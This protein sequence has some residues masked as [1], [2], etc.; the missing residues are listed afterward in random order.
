MG[1][2]RLYRSFPADPP[3]PS[4]FKERDVEW[5][6][7]VQVRIWRK[8]GKPSK[9]FLAI[10]DTGSP[11]CLFQASMGKAIGLDLEA[12]EEHPISGVVAGAELTA[13]FHRICL[14]VEDTW[15]VEV[16]AG[17]LEGFSVG[18]LLGRRGFF[19]TFSVLFDHSKQPPTFEMDKI[20][21]PN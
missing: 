7:A 17:F 18:A 10:A 11:Y 2:V 8:H 14:S 16:F 4:G 19:D 5:F 12:G 6:P 9:R 20:V 15:T 13:H 1:I 21:R 3:A